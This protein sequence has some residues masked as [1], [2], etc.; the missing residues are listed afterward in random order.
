MI[1]GAGG[2]LFSSSDLKLGSLFSPMGAERLMHFTFL[3]II[4]AEITCGIIWASWINT[5]LALKSLI[6]L[7]VCERNLWAA[8]EGGH[9]LLHQDWSLP[10]WA[11]LSSQSQ[12]CGGCSPFWKRTTLIFW[13]TL[14]QVRTSLGAQSQERNQA[15]QRT[16]A[17]ENQNS[18]QKS[19]VLGKNIGANTS[20]G[21]KYS[22]GWKNEWFSSGRGTPTVLS[23]P[24]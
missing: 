13:V 24:S 20:R 14:M 18:K 3:T 7:I 22:A 19:E 10:G 11:C 6:Q 8:G 15:T 17:L 5:A 16:K 21:K 9:G 4:A 12:Q 1:L 2:L 23:T